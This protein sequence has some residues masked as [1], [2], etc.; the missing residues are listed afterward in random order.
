MGEEPCAVEQQA[1]N[2]VAAESAERSPQLSSGGGFSSTCVTLS[3]GQSRTLNF[4]N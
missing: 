3:L 1:K 2:G 4:S